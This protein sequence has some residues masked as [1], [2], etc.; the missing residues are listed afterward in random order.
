MS[1]CIL[2]PARYEST[3]FPEKMLSP[4]QGI[5]MVVK[6]AKNMANFS[7]DVYVVTNHEKIQKAC[8]EAQVNCLM[9]KDEVPNGSMRIW[10]AFERFLQDKDYDFL[11]NVQGDE[12]LL[13]SRTVQ[14]LYEFHQATNFDIT[15]L[16][17]ERVDHEQSNP[18]IVKCALAKNK[19]QCLY[20]SRA[21]IPFNR[22]SEETTTWYHHIGVYCYKK[23]AL[24]KFVQLEESPLEKSEKL[25]QL[26]ALENGLTIG[27]SLI[28][29]KQELIGVDTP[30]DLEKVNRLLQTN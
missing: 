27:A 4:I 10:L 25:E 16:L 13:D 18:N 26:R 7:Q 2:I 6:V 9:V 11:I 24:K 14:K 21:T 8:N 22:E 30:E 19:S 1:A 12:P 23:S 29:Q 3:R 5:P 28:E 15:T 20:F 17:K